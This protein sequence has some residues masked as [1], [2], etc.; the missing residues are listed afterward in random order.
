[1]LVIVVVVLSLVVPRDIGAAFQNIGNVRLAH[2]AMA[3]AGGEGQLT[4]S[5][6][7]ATAMLSRALAWNPSSSGIAFRLGTASRLANN[8]RAA[9]SYLSDATVLDPTN[10]LAHFEFGHVLDMLGLRDQALQEWREARAAPYFLCLAKTRPLGK[11]EQP[12]RLAVAIAP[13][14]ADAHY[15]LAS[16]L[17]KL[18]RDAEAS[19]EYNI[20]AELFPQDSPWRYLAQGHALYHQ[21]LWD[22]SIAVFEMAI[23]L[24]DSDF[25]PTSKAMYEIGRALYWGKGDRDAAIKQFQAW[26]EVQGG[27]EPYLMIGDIWLAERDFEEARRWYARAQARAPQSNDPIS[28]TQK[29]YA[30]E[31]SH[32]LQRSEWDRAAQAYETLIHLAPGSPDGYVGLGLVVYWGRRDPD[33]AV[34]LLH[35]AIEVA[36]N[37]SRPYVYLGRVLRE[38][39]RLDEALPYARLSVEKGP[40]NPQAHA[41]LGRLLA[42]KGFFDEAILE[43]ERAVTLQPGEAWFYDA[44]GDVYLES[45]DPSLAAEAYR[46]GLDIAPG[47][48][49]LASKLQALEGR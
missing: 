29:S 36:T 3:E 45:G 49:E 27:V 28:R 31:G 12:L 18:G 20:A 17:Q 44:L 35:Q 16:V 14:W 43:L 1:M 32:Y 26:A 40:N 8:P 39:S 4:P 37:A 21:K 41:E 13:E 9:Q 24:S 47:W 25:V 15:E 6:G 10:S 11:D 7:T 23:R 19:S 42:A 2:A 38:E 5:L 33:H 46:R 30:E 48:E 34:Q 22:E